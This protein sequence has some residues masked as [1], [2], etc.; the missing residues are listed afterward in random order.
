MS[1]LLDDEYGTG[2]SERFT[3]ELRRSRDLFE[4]FC[5]D[6]L[7]PFESD[8][9]LEEQFDRLF[10]GVEILP[11]SLEAE[12]QAQVEESPLEAQS[13]LVPIS[14]QRQFTALRRAN[15][16][17]R[18]P[19]GIWVADLPYDRTRGLELIYTEAGSAP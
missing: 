7:K 6:D 14:Y 2:L 8:E 5:L 17:R 9:E 15:R 11:I 16:V 3:G 10:D 18:G 12:Y 1:L 19:K 4:R 13:M